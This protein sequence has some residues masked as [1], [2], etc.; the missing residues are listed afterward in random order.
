MHVTPLHSLSMQRSEAINII[1]NGLFIL[2]FSG[3]QV[4]LNAY[5]L[6]V[7]YVALE[8]S[9]QPSILR[10]NRFYTTQ[11]ITSPY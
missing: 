10:N 8:A 7:F 4:Y 3:D 9:A 1:A 11:A 2:E 5:T 6:K